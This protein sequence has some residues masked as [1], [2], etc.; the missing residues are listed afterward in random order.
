MFLPGCR[1]KRILHVWPSSFFCLWL[2]GTLCTHFGAGHFVFGRLC[3]VG[4]LPRGGGTRKA[5]PFRHCK[6]PGMAPWQHTAVAASCG[7]SLLS[8]EGRKLGREKTR[9]SLFLVCGGRKSSSSLPSPPR[10]LNSDLA[11]SQRLV[12]AGLPGR[13]RPC[14]SR[15]WRRR[16]GRR[17]AG[18][19]GEAERSSLHKLGSGEGGGG[20]GI[21][22]WHDEN[23]LLKNERNSSS[24][25]LSLFSKAAF[26][27][28]TL[29]KHGLEGK[30][31][32]SKLIIQSFCK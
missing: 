19:K 31:T 24:L 29:V 2:A 14:V 9:S 13:Q 25:S 17:H 4:G 3:V 6:Q 1:R 27:V 30:T 23:F 32:F 15:Q 28:K 21:V 10:S 20:G 8:R 11:S 12:A 18:S 26:G 22:K 16:L 5:C 7:P